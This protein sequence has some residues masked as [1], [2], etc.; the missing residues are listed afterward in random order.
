MRTTLFL[1]AALA[2][3]SACGADAP[4]FKPEA[5]TPENGVTV[6]GDAR[7]GVTTTL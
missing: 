1:T 6:S 3:L 4:P 5:A 2:L 7:I